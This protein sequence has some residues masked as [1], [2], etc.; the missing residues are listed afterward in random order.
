MWVD[1][2]V[3]VTTV[4]AVVGITA[5][6][7]WKKKTGKGGCCDCKYSGSCQSCPSKKTDDK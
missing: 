1:I 7:I 3:I 6:L 2:L 5:W 4:V